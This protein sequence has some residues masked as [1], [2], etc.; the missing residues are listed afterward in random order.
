MARRYSIVNFPEATVD[1]GC[2]VCAF[3]NGREDEYE[4]LLLS[5]TGDLETRGRAILIRDRLV[6]GSAI[7]RDN[8]LHLPSVMSCGK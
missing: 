7:R 8:L 6:D 4:L 3:S 5:S 1:C 2:H